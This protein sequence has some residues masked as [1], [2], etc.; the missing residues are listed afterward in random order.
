MTTGGSILQDILNV[1]CIKYQALYGSTWLYILGLNWPSSRLSQS[2]L[3]F[4]L[5]HEWI[6]T[7]MWFG[8]VK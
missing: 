7:I 5:F 3:I 1:I 4:F 6:D 8:W 2:W